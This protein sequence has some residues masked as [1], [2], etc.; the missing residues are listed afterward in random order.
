MTMMGGKSTVCMRVLTI[1]YIVE[2]LVEQLLPPRD[3][4]HRT[5]IR[6]LRALQAGRLVPTPRVSSGS[7]GRVNVAAA[8]TNSIRGGAEE[9]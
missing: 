3:W 7:A 8:Q 2:G 1:E 4:A 6:T 5:M 9:G